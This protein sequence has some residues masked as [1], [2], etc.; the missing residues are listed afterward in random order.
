MQCAVHAMPSV[1]STSGRSECLPIQ[2]IKAASWPG[3]ALS[4]RKFKQQKK[5]FMQAVLEGQLIRWLDLP[6]DKVFVT[7]DPKGGVHPSSH[8][9][10]PAT[11]I[12]FQHLFLPRM[13]IN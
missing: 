6:P 10:F 9:S 3:P 2:K 11:Q 12:S 1:A 5:V 4:K 13:A 8:F 7:E